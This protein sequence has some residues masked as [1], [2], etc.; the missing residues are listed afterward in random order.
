MPVLGGCVLAVGCAVAVYGGTSGDSSLVAGG[1]V[2]AELG[3]LACIPVIVGFLGRLGRMLPLSP[4]WRCATR[5]ATVAV[6]HPRS[7]P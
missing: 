1:S 7:R 3:L 2:A 4:G 6:P 5:P